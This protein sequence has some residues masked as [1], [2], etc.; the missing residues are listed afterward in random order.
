M[1]GGGGSGQDG[2]WADAA[3]SP[4]RTVR[5]PFCSV[6]E[7]TCDREHCSCRVTVHA[8]ALQPEERGRRAFRDPGRTGRARAC[9][10]RGDMRALVSEQRGLAS[11]S[12]RTPRVPDPR[13][14]RPRFE[15]RSWDPERKRRPLQAALPSAPGLQRV[16]TSEFVRGYFQRKDE[17]PVEEERSRLRGRAGPNSCESLP[18]RPLTCRVPAGSHGLALV[19]VAPCPNYPSPERAEGGSPWLRRGPPPPKPSR[20]VIVTAS[21]ERTEKPKT[22][23]SRVLPATYDIPSTCDQESCN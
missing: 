6:P 21:G 13:P 17:G 12:R 8:G 10:V 23:W 22:W 9:E 4:S 19:E 3:L 18:S 2:L 14:E 20:S 1:E 11:E 5:V 7:T 15:P 16:L